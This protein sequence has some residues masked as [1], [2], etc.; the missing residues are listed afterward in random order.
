MHTT[1]EDN[2]QS[3][4]VLTVYLLVCFSVGSWSL[5]LLEWGIIADLLE[6]QITFIVDTHFCI[7]RTEFLK[8]LND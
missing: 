7:K 6:S 4:Y 8:G 1:Y 5:D 3:A 2:P